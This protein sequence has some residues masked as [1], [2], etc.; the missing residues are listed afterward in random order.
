[1]TKKWFLAAVIGIALPLAG[2]V[3]SQTD[4]F[5]VEDLRPG[6]KGTGK[7]CFGGS[8]PEEFQVEILGVLRGLN[9]GSDAILARLT[10]GPLEQIGVFEGMSGSPVYIEGKLLG[11][12]AFSFPFAKEAIGGI[13]PI[14]DM[15][16]SFTEAP[17][18]NA[19]LIRSALRKSMLWKYQL[20]APEGLGPLSPALISARDTF[21]Q[22]S[23][24]PFAGQPLVPIETPLYLGG[25]SA[26]TL[27][28]F[29]PQF[30]ALGLS[31]ASGGLARTVQ[32]GS[33]KQ[34]SGAPSDTTPLEPGSNLVIPLV[35]G[36]L[37]V[38][39]GG[40]VT[41]IHGNRLYAFGHPLFNLGFSELPMYKGRT[42]TVFP[43]LQSSFKIVEATDPVGILRQD[44]GLGIYGVL[45]EEARMIPMRIR[46]ITSRGVRKN[47][48][49]EIAHDR[50]LT[51]LLINL[52]VF[53]TIVAT[54]RGM[55]VS[56]VSVTGRVNIKGRQPVEIQNRFASDSSSPAYA[57]LSVA[58]PVNFLLTS[59]YDSIELQDIDLE[60]AAVEDDMAATL[61]SLRIDRPELSAGD[62][63]K[64]D[65]SYQKGGGETIRESYPLRIPPGIIPGP[66][67][68]L[69]A[70][71]TTVMEMDAREQGEELIPRDLDQLIKLINNIRKNDRLYL[72]LFR[73]KTGVVVKGEGMP[74]LPPSII[75]ILKSERDSG[76]MNPI[77]TVP[78]MEYELPLGKYV[79]FGSQTLNLVINP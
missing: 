47:L 41:Y 60:I 40:T 1:M 54:E 45:G 67:S 3:W 31:A 9:P 46:L 26:E 13:T 48:N 34:Q 68:L 49:F 51:P 78:L 20:P 73:R 61:T 21:M 52:S 79:V 10:G 17:D 19:P 70:D 6:M 56:T 69:V 71:G 25:F 63:L 14:D 57:A 66:I 29:A 38:S 55:G 18:I 36:D 53:N 75:S 24:A 39:A 4:F 62:T 7:T 32:A 8:R 42:L 28:V 37:D 74:G 35:R 30:R 5:Q 43:S 33:R 22:P 2:S 12:V 15:V 58:I 72:R 65:I 77:Q 76:G 59:G 44:R 27:R 50:V 16:D 11:A 23:L 64:I